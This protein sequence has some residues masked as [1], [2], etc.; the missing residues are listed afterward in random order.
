MGTH[1]K[2]AWQRFVTPDNTHLVSPEAIDFVDKLLR[3]DH[4]VR[5]IGFGV[6]GLA[7]WGARELRE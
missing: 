3:Y 1:S 6:G 5:G 4:Q 7:G 2:K